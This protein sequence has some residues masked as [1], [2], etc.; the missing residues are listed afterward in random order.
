MLHKEM[1]GL[2]LLFFVL[3]VVLAGTP[4]GRLERGCAPISWGGSIVTSLAVLATPKYQ[5]DLEHGTDQV[6]YSCEFTAWRLFYSADYNRWLAT[7]QQ[8]SASSVPASAQVIPTAPAAP[9][10]QSTAGTAPAVA[11]QSG[12]AR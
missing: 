2:G 5:A 8:A 12:G 10:A 7:Q 9:G 1:F 3:W 11:G 4:S 6:V